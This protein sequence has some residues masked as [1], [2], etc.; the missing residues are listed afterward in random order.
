[1]ARRRF[2]ID[3]IPDKDLPRLQARMVQTFPLGMVKLV[4]L[5][6]CA[7]F[8]ETWPPDF[9]ELVSV[10]TRLL[11]LPG[12]PL[13][14]EDGET[15]RLRSLGPYGRHPF[16]RAWYA[17]SETWSGRPATNLCASTVWT[18]RVWLAA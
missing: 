12:G 1:M 16:A 11:L 9:D 13:V 17:W 4:T 10:A 5:H 14:L 8:M 3:R 18:A 6:D 15:T 7:P 2:L